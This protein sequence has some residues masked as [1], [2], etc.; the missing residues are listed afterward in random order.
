MKCTNPTTDRHMILSQRSFFQK[1][2]REITSV[3]GMISSPYEDSSFSEK[4]GTGNNKPGV[5]W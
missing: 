2:H 3:L 5:S 1:P 4:L